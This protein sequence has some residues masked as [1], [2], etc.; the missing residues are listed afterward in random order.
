MQTG[1]EEA[2]LLAQV[3]NEIEQRFNH[4]D[5]PAHG[6]EHIRRV[7]D[8]AMYIAEQE[9]ADG[10]ICGMAALLHD[11]GRLSREHGQHHAEL[12]ASEAWALLSRQKV[13]PEAQEAIIHAIVAH[14]FSHGIEP[15]TLEAYIVR[16][17][18]RLDSL[19]AIGILRWAIT[20]AVRRTPNTLTYHPADPFAEQHIP[21]DQ[22]YM[23]DHFFSKLLKLGDTISTA[24][25]HK[26][27]EQ[28]MAFMHAYLDE[29]RRE[30]IP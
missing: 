15:R 5:D 14:S 28:R 17:A 24:T 8:L 10:F 13:S 22:R 6:W 2:R 27:A 16:D 25:G 12:S 30:L 3:Y 23:L 19:G 7:Y 20:G 18:D 11:L 21:D 9:G 1:T 4:S 26:L 29:F